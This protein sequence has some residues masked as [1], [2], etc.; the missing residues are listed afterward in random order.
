[1]TAAAVMSAQRKASG[2]TARHGGNR[3]NLSYFALPCRPYAVRTCAAPQAPPLTPHRWTPSP[4]SSEKLIRTLMSQ[5]YARSAEH[6]LLRTNLLFSDSKLQNGRA[7]ADVRDGWR[8]FHFSNGRPPS[9]AIF[10]WSNAPMVLTAKDAMSE[11]RKAC[12]HSSAAQNPTLCAG[13]S[14]R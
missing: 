14:Y 2:S 13:S 5:P 4:V 8:G 3:D 1:M 12:V 10:S 6:F 9:K 7:D 11:S